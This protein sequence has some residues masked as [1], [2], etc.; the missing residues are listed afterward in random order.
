MKEDDRRSREASSRLNAHRRLLIGLV[1]AAAA[2]FL[3]P[4]SLPA[5]ARF[6]IAWDSAVLTFL[7]T[8]WW[9]VADCPPE[10]MRETV[11]ANDQGR[12]G[13][14]LLVL[15][16]VCASLA[17]IFLL[18]QNAKDQGPPPAQVVLAVFTV[19]CSWFATHTMFALHYAHRFY[20]D[21]PR[22]PEADATGG[23]DFPGDEPPDYW[24]F[25]YF[26]FVIGMTSQVSD[27]Q[28]TSRPMRRLVF[29]HG[30]LSFIFY[31]V[32]LALSINIVA[33][34]L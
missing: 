28:V 32:I 21:D 31:T 19:V 1:V 5:A 23:L 29:W 26:A 7:L 12:V 25:L 3:M 9:V 13:I 11:L 2:G 24:D 20:R 27:V 16:A 14:L 4:A 30:I 10:E 8:T 15:L 18:M 17:E 22:T 33:S 34:A 6:A